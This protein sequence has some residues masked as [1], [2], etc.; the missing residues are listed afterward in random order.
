MCL[1]VLSSSVMSNSSWPL[2]LQPSRLLCPWGF[3]R[4]EYWNGLPC[5]PPRDLPSR[6]I[7]PRSPT[8]QAYSLWTQPSGKPIW[9]CSYVSS[10]R[11]SWFIAEEHHTLPILLLWLI[12]RIFSYMLQIDF[13]SSTSGI[14]WSGGE[15]RAW[16]SHLLRG[17][18]RW[19]SLWNLFRLISNV[20]VLLSSMNSN[21]R[22]FCNG[23]L[24]C[25]RHIYE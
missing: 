3:S 23:F 4:Q 14:T 8:L 24:T 22:V 15:A 1:V 19:R 16:L 20:M 9:Q 10:S 12:E 13:F 21:A 11:R 7:K 18:T 2:R 17:E 6:G 25:Q 5:P